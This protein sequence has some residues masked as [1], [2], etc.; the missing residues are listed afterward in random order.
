M[1]Q[2]LLVLLRLIHILGGVFWVG[3]V[4]YTGVF[5]LPTVRELGPD[6]GKFMGRMMSARKVPQ[7]LGMAAGLT[8]LSGIIMY[9]WFAKNGGRAWSASHQA[10]VLGFGGLCGIIAGIVGGAVVGRA[11]E[12][13]GSL[14]S[15]TAGG[16]PSPAVA[17]EMQRLQAKVN[18]GAK[19]VQWLLIVAAACMAVARY[20]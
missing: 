11:A 2:W 10:M 9:G 17:Q 12:K 19:L 18:S 4:L 5:L 7:R 6:G 1:N 15:Q 3:S 16:P 13:L 20:V 14:G 8:V